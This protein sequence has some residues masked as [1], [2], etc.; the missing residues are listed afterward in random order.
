MLVRH[1]DD[2]AGTDR[3]IALTEGGKLLR[4]V[5]VLTLDDGCGFSLSDVRVTGGW[6]CDLHHAAHVGITLVVAGLLEVKDLTRGASWRLG[7]GMLYVAGPKD[8]HR[9]TT[10]G[11]AH[12]VC[13]FNPALTGRE[14]P[15][16]DGAFAATGEL[17]PAWRGDGA[18]TMFALGD[19]QARHSILRGDRPPPWRSAMSGTVRMSHYLGPEDGCGLTASLPRGTADSMLWYKNH[20]EA[21]YVLEGE[22]TVEDLA[23]GEVWELRPGSLYVV[24]PRDRHHLKAEQ[25][26]YFISVFN[27]PLKGDAARDADGAYP[28]TGEVPPAW[29]A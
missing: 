3:E 16:A 23:S 8:R 28:P 25:E 18:R 7:A 13:L 21:N 17:P 6:S 19:E 1:I 5:G 27:P 22:A 10:A 29:R 9:V 2:L 4:S 26:V 12:L 20:V 14:A 24:G 15:D 11:D